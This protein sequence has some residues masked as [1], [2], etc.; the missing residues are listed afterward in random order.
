MSNENADFFIST[1]AIQRKGSISELVSCLKMH[2]VAV[3]AS[4]FSE[5]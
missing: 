1:A 5:L 4:K 3:G 2:A